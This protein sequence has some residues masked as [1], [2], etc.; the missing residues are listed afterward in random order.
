MRL[1]RKQL[2]G[3]VVAL[4][5]IP[6]VGWLVLFQTGHVAAPGK[7]L[8]PPFN[9]SDRIVSIEVSKNDSGLFVGTFHGHEEGAKPLTGDEFFEEL[10]RRKK[11]LPVFY[12]W[13]DVTSLGGVLWVVFGFLAQAVFTARMLVQWY[14][15]EK[16]KSSVVPPAFWWLSLLGASMLLIYFVWRKEPVGFFGQATGWFI[17]VRNL[18]FIYGKKPEVG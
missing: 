9:M 18:W 1:K 6:T 3:V 5:V 14:A 10:F 16:V 13:L 8:L 15:S 12:K 2:I 11:S 7:P 17:Y 4:L